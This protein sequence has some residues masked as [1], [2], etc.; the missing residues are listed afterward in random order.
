MRT[1]R[2]QSGDPFY[3]P[4][5][6]GVPCVNG[7]FEVPPGFD[8]ECDGLVVPWSWATADGLVVSEDR[9]DGQPTSESPLV[10]CVVAPLASEQDIEDR[11]WLQ[12]RS[13]DWEPAAQ[14]RWVPLGRRHIMMGTIGSAVEI[15]LTFRDARGYGTSNEAKLYEVLHFE[16]AVVSAQPNVVLLNI[17]DLASSLSL[18]N[19]VLCNTMYSSVGAFHAAVEVYG[20][21]WSFYRTPNPTSCGVCKSLRAR[22]HPVHVYRQSMILGTTSLKD[23]EVRYLIRAQLAPKWVG[24]DYDLLTRNCIHF[25]DE[26]LLVLGVK[27]VPDWVTGLHE[28]GSSILR[29]PWPLSI[30]FGSGRGEKPQPPEL[31]EEDVIP[32]EAASPVAS[33]AG[34]S[35]QSIGDLKGSTPKRTGSF[36]LQRSS[37]FKPFNE[38]DEASSHVSSHATT[39]RTATTPGVPT[40]G[41][42]PRSVEP[43]GRMS[44]RAYGQKDPRFHQYS[45]GFQ[46]G[47]PRSKE[48]IHPARETAV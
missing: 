31:E 7:T 41:V 19:A 35:S 28:T 29:I 48:Q 26:L 47:S 40:P 11:D 33:D 8:Q 36:Q 39:P 15:Q 16:R 24:G 43:V 22:H 23:W 12:F 14:E 32:I 34:M 9:A 18:A 45:G 30:F 17:F 3:T 4:K 21:E 5:V 42:T 37:P 27:P 25:C 1:F 46:G 20:E 6:D 2:I 10:R 13:D 44:G 38:D